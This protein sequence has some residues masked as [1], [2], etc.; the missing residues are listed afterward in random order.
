MQLQQPVQE[1]NL[2]SNDAAQKGAKYL[3]SAPG[4][5]WRFLIIKL[6]ISLD[7]QRDSEVSCGLAWCL[8]QLRFLS[9]GEGA[10]RW[11]FPHPWHS[12]AGSGPTKN[13]FFKKMLRGGITPFLG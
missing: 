7:T 9:Q 2:T 1:L 6:Q 5:Q 4:S 10:T 11:A 8:H 12:A 3:S 13:G